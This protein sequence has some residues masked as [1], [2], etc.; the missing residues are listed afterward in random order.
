MIEVGDAIRIMRTGELMLATDSDLDGVTFVRFKDGVFG[1]RTQTHHFNQS[2]VRDGIRDGVYNPDAP[3][4]RFDY[5][6]GYQFDSERTQKIY[7]EVESGNF[8]SF[9]EGDRFWNTVD[10]EP[11]H[12]HE[13]GWETESGIAEDLIRF[14]DGSVESYTTVVEAMR[15]GIWLLVCD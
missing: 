3:S 2:E 7:D 14:D 11:V 8:P 4:D 10:C 1:N 13:V 15:E 9:Q 5:L 12:V 6:D